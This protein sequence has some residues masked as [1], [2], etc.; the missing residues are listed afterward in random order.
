MRGLIGVGVLA[1]TV[2]LIVLLR[3]RDNHE[4][5]IVRWPGAWILVGLLLTMSFGTDVALI[6]TSIGILD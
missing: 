3:P 2:L 5:L 4:R 6:A 1:A